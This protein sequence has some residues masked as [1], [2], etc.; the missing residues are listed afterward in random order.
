MYFVVERNR[1]F[2]VT[3]EDSRQFRYVGK[4]LGEALALY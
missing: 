1:D 2:I 3:L 4:I